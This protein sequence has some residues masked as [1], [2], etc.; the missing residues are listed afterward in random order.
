MTE[1]CN[2]SKSINYIAGNKIFIL[3]TITRETTAELIGRLGLLVD[4]LQPIQLRTIEPITN[5]YNVKT[6]APIIDIYINSGGGD[7][8]CLYSITSLMDIA[9]TKGALIRTTVMGHAESAASMLA[10]QGDPGLRIMHKNSFHFAHYGSTTMT[11][12]SEPAAA[13]FAD[14]D[15]RMTEQAKQIYLSNTA[16]TR[17]EVNKM[18]RAETGFAYPE[19]CLAKSM[20]D[21]IVADGK[22]ISR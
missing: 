12:T 13:S 5:P 2:V 16:L 10:I 6:N 1:I 8:H 11:I 9:R 20:C 3:G 4:N 15:K 17:T 14:H 22:F 18:F 21:W 19:F 7:A